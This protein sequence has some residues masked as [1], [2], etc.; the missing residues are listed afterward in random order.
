MK[1]TST[2]GRSRPP[3][4][5]P[6]AL[7]WD[8]LPIAVVE[9]QRLTTVSAAA[10][11]KRLRAG[12]TVAEARAR[13]ADL[14]LVPHDATALT[15]AILRVSAAL[16]AA[17][18]QVTP[19]SGA[20][21]TWWVGA[22]GFDGVGGEAALARTLATIVRAWHPGARVA[23]ADACIGA[24]AATWGDAT[25]A[26]RRGV[27]THVDAHDN[28]RGDT[29]SDTR[30]DTRGVIVHAGASAAY[31]AP[32]PL[33]LIPMDAE[34]REGLIALGLETAGAFAALA[35]EDVEARW[36]DQGL[37]AWRL[38]QGEDA[39]RPSLVRAER[40][41]T[42][43]A[44]L[45]VPSAT[46]EP[47]LF[48]VRAALDRLVTGLVTDARAAAVVAITLT[49]DDVR[50][51]TGEPQRAHTVTREV[52]CPKPLAR[53]AP[54][55]E[56]CRGLLDSWTLAAP[57]TA[58]EIAITAT[59]PMGG[60]QGGLLDSAWRDPAAADAALARLRAELGP[61]T[62]VRPAVRD[63]HRP[64]AAGV[65]EDVAVVSPAPVVPPAAAA[66]IA[67]GFA[68]EGMPSKGACE[69]AGEGELA[70]AMRTLAPAAAVQ[71]EVDGG[72]PRA[73]WW[74]G[75]RVALSRVH[76]PERLGGEW[77]SVPWQR[78]YWRGEGALDGDASAD[79]VLYR[80]RQAPDHGWFLHGWVD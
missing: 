31:L 75:R 42:V 51:A 54:L 60:E 55:F 76:G 21:G 33:A 52:R 7:A 6:R 59:A 15:D 17:S 36:G 24:R 9:A 10:A 44:E 34:V 45:P 28:P 73:L 78:D 12:M 77:W 53:L 39:R 8:A 14:T 25:D 11:A 64:E 58:V 19:A 47:V 29:R 32:A 1:P 79:L 70:G 35:P 46:L 2:T 40:P 80:D 48:L 65:W 41:R 23:I 22:T 72:A 38:A 43:A 69:S 37:A 63:A 50:G 67:D 18:P 13:C 27:A 3:R 62:V 61:G 20:P 16:V 4:E 5:E 71:V 68:P 57:V 26:V 74:Q 49:L 30:G 56:R 66:P